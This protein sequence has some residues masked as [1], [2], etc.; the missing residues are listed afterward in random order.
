MQRTSVRQRAGLVHSVVVGNGAILSVIVLLSAIQCSRVD[1]HANPVR[2]DASVDHQEV[3][4]IVRSVDVG[5][6]TPFIPGSAT[7][8][9]SPSLNEI[10][11]RFVRPHLPDA[12]VCYEAEVSRH[13]GLQGR[14][15]VRFTI[16]ADGKVLMADLQGS[17]TGNRA[18]ETCLVER[19]KK[20]QFPRPLGGGTV[21][22]SYTFEFGPSKPPEGR[23]H[24]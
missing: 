12:H 5:R 7:S 9:R 3:P 21:T 15:T 16:G 2:A 18:V 11:G 23:Q 19:A 17:T 4:N 8:S 14:V 10:F 13:P 24:G 20:W 22:R 1:E 6:G